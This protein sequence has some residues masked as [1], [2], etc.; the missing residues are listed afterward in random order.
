[1]Y[2]LDD[3][4]FAYSNQSNLVFGL[5]LASILHGGDPLKIITGLLVEWMIKW[6]TGSMEWEMNVLCFNRRLLAKI[7]RRMYGWPNKSTPGWVRMKRRMGETPSHHYFLVT[8]VCSY[9]FLVTPTRDATRWP[10]CLT[11][12]LPLGDNFRRR[13]SIRSNSWFMQSECTDNLK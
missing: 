11:P 12:L 10:F 3:F 4:L 6:W 2:F 13:R 5:H 8:S 7:D 9:R 1:M